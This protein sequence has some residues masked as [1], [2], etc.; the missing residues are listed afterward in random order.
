MQLSIMWVNAGEDGFNRTNEKIED[1]TLS[2]R[3]GRLN[4]PGI[5]TCPVSIL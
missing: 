1:K 2:I 5:N 4:L 3:M